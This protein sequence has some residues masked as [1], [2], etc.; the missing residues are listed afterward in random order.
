KQLDQSLGFFQQIKDKYTNSN[1]A[2][3]AYYYIGQIYLSRR[4]A[5]DLDEAFA[6]FERV[7]RVFPSSDVVDRALIGAGTALKWRGDFDKAYEEFAKL[8]VRFSDSPVAPQA[9]L[10]M[11][12]CA[13]YSDHYLEASTDFQQVI[14]RFPDSDFAKQARDYNTIL[15]R[16]Y[17]APASDKAIIYA[18]DP[19]FSGTIAE[20][21]DP[22]SLTSD[23]QGNLYLVD[24]GKKTVTAFDSKGKAAGSVASVSSVAPYSIFVDD[25]DKK[26]VATETSVL[27]D[28]DA[29]SFNYSKPG[30]SETEPLQEIR[31]AAV[32]EF[33]DYFVVSNKTTG[34]LVYDQKGAPVP[35]LSSLR[36]EKEYIKVLTNSRNQIYALD[37]QRK[38][39]NVFSSEGRSILL[40]GPTTQIDFDKIEDFAVDRINHIYLLTKN[41]RTVMVFDPKGKL[42]RTIASTKGTAVAFEDGKVLTVGPSGAIFVLDKDAHRILKFG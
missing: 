8:K 15:Y 29:V 23:S 27:A 11:G 9:Q 25:R 40:L 22:T 13:L 38:Q 33:G 7:T 37:K 5:N 3:T 18:P 14:D 1:S 35:S 34:I 31:Y 24:K 20:I 30:K 26:Y 21:D 16:L 12:V 6:N 36:N 17:V 19:S 41:P 42:L 4:N 39:L 32:N 10:E 2:P 28:K